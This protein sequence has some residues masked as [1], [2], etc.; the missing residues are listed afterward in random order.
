[1]ATK[2]SSSSVPGL[3]D[4]VEVAPPS[5]QAQR[6]GRWGADVNSVRSRRSESQAELPF[7][8]LEGVGEGESLRSRSRVRAEWIQAPDFLAPL[9]RQVSEPGV[10][11]GELGALSEHLAAGVAQAGSRA[12]EPAIEQLACASASMAVE[13][14]A[15]A[16]PCQGCRGR[17]W[18][19]TVLPVCVCNQSDVG[20]RGT[21]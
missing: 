6:A 7:L 12:V 16:T 9:G 5:C 8:M 3:G 13:G 17:G 4:E 1:M 20:K 21:G 14:G 2:V 19:V 15:R 11:A 10:K 18:A